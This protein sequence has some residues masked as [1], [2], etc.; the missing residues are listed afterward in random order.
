M[1]LAS[2]FA[3]ASGMLGI[4]P[5]ALALLRA[6]THAAGTGVFASS[7]PRGNGAAHSAMEI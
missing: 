7:G 4:L 3:A 2:P 1:G 6:V 5:A